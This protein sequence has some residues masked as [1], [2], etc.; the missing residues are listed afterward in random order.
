MTPPEIYAAI[1]ALR[2]ATR[3][4]Q[5]TAYERALLALAD[6]V[7]AYVATPCQLRFDELRVAV[8]S[9][10][11]AARHVTRVDVDF[12]SVKRG[13][14]TRAAA[15]LCGW[16]GPERGTMDLA[17]DDALAHERASAKEST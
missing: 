16:R 12:S 5:R 10:F 3:P 6:L 2:H 11:A 17:A 9:R 8:P 1:M 4:E 15:C 13:G 14:S 7:D